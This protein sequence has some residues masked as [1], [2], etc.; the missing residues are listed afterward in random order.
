MTPMERFANNNI[1]KGHRLGR[2]SGQARMHGS[3]LIIVLALLASPFGAKAETDAK[4]PE[5]KG[6]PAAICANPGVWI[7]PATGK[8]ASPLEFFD[9]LASKQVVLLGESHNKA[10]HHRWQLHN[11]AALHS[12]SKPLILG[13]EMFPRRVQPVLDKWVKGELSR[14]AFLKE[15]EWSRVWGFDADLYMPMF[16]F[17]RMNAIP[18]VALNVERA[19]ISRV[20]KEGW[21]NIP[22]AEREGLTE[23]ASAPKEYERMLAEIYLL[24]EAMRK[25]PENHGKLDP[26]KADDYRHQAEVTD[27]KLAELQ[28]VPEFRHFVEGQL[29]WDRAMAEGI[30]KASRDNPGAL[31]IGVMGSGHV[32]NLNGVPH[33]LK[34]LDIAENAALIPV[35]AGEDCEAVSATYANA[36]FTL[37]T[38]EEQEKPKLKLGVVIRDEGG[39]ALVEMVSPDSV[40][41]AL[42][43]KKGD[44]IISA[45]GFDVTSA[46]DLIEIIGRQAPGTWLPLEIERDGRHLELVAKFPSGEEKKERKI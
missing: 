27:E 7:N 37:K 41:E 2:R 40:A 46:A 35:E 44:K 29:T 9:D 6:L 43:I 15:V 26:D 31:I 22:Q 32:E 25:A 10:E 20:G 14:E 39:A 8:A 24:K 38:P 34:S 13:F 21:D 5:A 17:A 33:Q 28:A 16:D 36:I 1:N 11:I 23:P 4:S 19:L 30:S 42:E 18:M 3:W 12:R 45:A